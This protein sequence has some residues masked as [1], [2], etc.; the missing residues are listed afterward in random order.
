[1]GV[2][3]STACAANKKEAALNNSREHEE[4]GDATAPP[5]VSPPATVSVAFGTVSD[6]RTLPTGHT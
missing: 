2:E 1:M 6:I 3:D 5:S 4:A